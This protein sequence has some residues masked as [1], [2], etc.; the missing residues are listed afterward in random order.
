VVA[1]ILFDSPPK[2]FNEVQ[3]TMELGQKD[4]EMSCCLNYLLNKRSLLFEVWL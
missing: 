4:T 2:E 1:E 3:F